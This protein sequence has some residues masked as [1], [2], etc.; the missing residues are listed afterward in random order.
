M[1][2][3]RVATV[4]AARPCQQNHPERLR[5]PREQRAVVVGLVH[6]QCLVERLLAASL[7]SSILS[8]ERNARL[9]SLQEQLTLAHYDEE[10]AVSAAINNGEDVARSG[11]AP[12]WAVLQV[13]VE[14]EQQAA[15]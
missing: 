7:E 1:T 4:S 3:A 11:S 8:T 12:A 2:D 15:A 6:P 13:E 10:Q 9:Q 5:S 14:H